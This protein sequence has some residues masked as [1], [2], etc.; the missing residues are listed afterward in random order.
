MF[1]KIKA[2]VMENFLR[3]T[4]KAVPP[5]PNSE[6]FPFSRPQF[7]ELDETEIEES[8]NY[9]VRPILIPRD[10]QKIPWCAGYAESINGGKSDF[11]E[12]QVATWHIIIKSPHVAESKKDK[13]PNTMIPVAADRGDQ[14]LQSM[15]SEI[16]TYYGMFDGHAGYGAAIMAANLLH[17][18]LQEKLAS[19][20]ELILKKLQTSDN[21]NERYQL[22]LTGNFSVDDLVIGALESAFLA[23]DE[24]IERERSTY[25]IKGGCTALVAIL[26]LGK[27]YIANAGD[28][29]AVL[30]T[31]EKMEQMS[32]EFTPESE[33]DRIKY[34]GYIQPLLLHN[35]FSY[36][37]FCRRLNKGD[38]GKH[39]LCKFPQTAG[40]SM[41]K[42]DEHDL[43]FPLVI[44][45]GKKARLLGTIG[46]TR[47]FG[48]HDLKVKVLDLS[49]TTWTED[50]VLVMGTD[51]LWDVLDNSFVADSV[52]QSLTKTMNT[53]PARYCEAA[54][55]L[56]NEAR[57]M[58]TGKD[59]K[60]QDDSVASFDDITVLVIP[61]KPYMDAYKAKLLCNCLDEM[62][63]YP[64]VVK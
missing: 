24:Q 16:L 25:L 28:S 64:L 55:G 58:F 47:G 21:L 32:K 29:R 3:G 59:W 31:G 5:P 22:V 14:M 18:H 12:D 11:N 7:L 45:E 15:E 4:F 8:R 60:R 10:V 36:F 6:K 23:M 1:N 33:K 52:R 41:K 62:N 54:Q 9:A 26:F 63:T 61:I 42:V 48:D 37:E 19:V 57:G 46:V 27:L 49:V 20:I 30:F 56:V 44:G 17:K 34:L 2:M 38:I 53:D 39:V 13:S 50:D 35:E 40:W 43:R 51:G